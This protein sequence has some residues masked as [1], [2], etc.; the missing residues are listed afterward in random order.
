M[1][2][3]RWVDDGEYRRIIAGD[4]PLRADDANASVTEEATAAAKEYRE[5][6]ARSEDP[7]FNLVRR[8][9]DGT[10]G[11]GDWVGSRTER[12]RRWVSGD[13]PFVAEG[14]PRNGETRNGETPDPG[15]PDGS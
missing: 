8:L 12:V 11:V 1:E 4:Y 5:S 15:S 7:L 10:A 3:R 14:E 2:L 13:A 6:F 9:G